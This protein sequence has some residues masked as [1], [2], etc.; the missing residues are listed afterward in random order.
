VLTS[1]W[2]SP[3]EQNDVVLELVVKIPSNLTIKLDGMPKLKIFET[4]NGYIL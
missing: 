4:L 2:V 3:K 1:Y